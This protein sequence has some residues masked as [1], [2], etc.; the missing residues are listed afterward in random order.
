MDGFKNIEEK[1][2]Q[3]TRKYYTSE[4]I[5]G[6]ILFISLGFIYLFFTLFLEYFLWLKPTARTILFWLFLVVEIFLLIRFIAIPIFKLIGLRKGITFEQS[7]KIIGSHFPEVQDKLLNVLQLKQNTN[8]SDL[9]LASID[10]KSAELQPIP[11]VKAVDFKQNS[12]YLKYAIIPVL[13]WLI[14]LFTGTN[15]ALTQSLDRVVNHNTAYNP[16]APFL[17]SIVNS[18][19]E[20]I[21]GKSITV[22]VNVAGKVLPSEAKIHF[23][24]QQYFLQNN[25]NGTFSYTFSDVQEPINFFIEG[26]GIES[27]DFIIDVIKTPTINNISLDINY[28]RYLGKRNET[29]K[30][31]GNIV[32]PEGTRITWNVVANQTDSVAFI[33]E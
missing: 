27:Q 32:V 14:I 29:I 11:F 8:Q 15:E 18:K 33:N 26:N 2:H 28:P 7:S 5:K 30:N 17:F 23:D 21:Q 20:V 22:L 13:I 10:Q 12:K 1:L 19:L 16:P 4:L 6:G 9:L 3:F 25:S 24:N 31:S